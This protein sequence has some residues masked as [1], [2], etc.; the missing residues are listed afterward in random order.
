MF[1]ATS[2]GLRWALKSGNGNVNL[3]FQIREKMLTLKT[4][5]SSGDDT[6][7][8][9]EFMECLR[10]CNYKFLWHSKHVV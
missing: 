1:A 8:R 7:G 4:K 6:K 5:G 10:S 9:A 3:L 2:A